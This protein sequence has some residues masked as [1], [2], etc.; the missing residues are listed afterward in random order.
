MPVNLQK[1]QKIS[2]RKEN[3]ES[4]KK[5]MV[6]LGWDEAESDYDEEIDCDASAIVC[7]HGRL[8]N[9]DDVVFY[10]KL[11]HS[12]GAIVHQGDNLSGGDGIEDSEQIFVDLN[13]LGPDYDRIVFVVTIYKAH[14]KNQ[15]FASI[16]NAFIRIVDTL[17]GNELC[18]FELNECE[19]GITAMIV[20]ELVK[21]GGEW[22]FSAIGQGTKDNGIIEIAKRF[23]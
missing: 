13:S 16:N 15:D 3:A 18:R 19:R 12:S 2:L 6:G 14:E 7:K 17:S 8:V 9:W 21:E 4:I 23:K 1:G 20:G 10:N 5:V 22:K 11:R